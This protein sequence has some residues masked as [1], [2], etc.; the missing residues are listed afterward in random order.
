MVVIVYSQWKMCQ[1]CDDDR[2]HLL[3]YLHL[4]ITSSFSAFPFFR[5]SPFIFS[6]GSVYL[7]TPFIIVL[8][9]LAVGF[10]LLVVRL[11]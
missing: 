6:F 2:T 8:Y 5:Y 1:A 10:C 4:F 11:G 9:Y 7:F 3:F